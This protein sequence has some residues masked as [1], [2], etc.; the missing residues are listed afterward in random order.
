M[1]KL[2]TPGKNDGEVKVWV[3][4]KVVADWPDLIVRTVNTLKIDQ[5]YIGLHAIHSERL[6]KKWYDNVVIAKSYIGPMSDASPTPTATPTPTPTPT[7]TPTPILRHQH[8]HQR[9]PLPYP[10]AHTN[11]NSHCNANPK[12]YTNSNPY[13]RLQLQLQLLLLLHLPL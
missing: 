2:N 7:A 1:T 8:P 10:Y 4:G 9:R 13:S 6:N 11:S 3:D 5:V 12:S